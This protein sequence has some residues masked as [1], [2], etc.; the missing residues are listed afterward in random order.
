MELVY[1]L[2]DGQQG[3]MQV[4]G[5]FAETVEWSPVISGEY[6]PHDVSAAA[7]LVFEGENLAEAEAAVE[8][9]TCGLPEAS[10]YTK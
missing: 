5:D 6:G 10:T 4:E 7:E 3:T 9:L 2:S 1:N 8:A